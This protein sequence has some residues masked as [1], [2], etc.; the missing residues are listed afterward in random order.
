M[1]LTERDKENT[2]FMSLALKNL[3]GYAKCNSKIPHQACSPESDHLP[4]GTLGIG[5]PKYQEEH[6]TPV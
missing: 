1:M 3:W 5:E 4:T 2:L 6:P